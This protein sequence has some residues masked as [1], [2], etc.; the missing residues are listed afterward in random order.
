MEQILCAMKFFIVLSGDEE[1]VPPKVYWWSL[2]KNVSVTSL[3]TLTSVSV[4]I[5]FVA[6]IGPKRTALSKYIGLFEWSSFRERKASSLQSLIA[7]PW[8]D[9]TSYG[10]QPS[11]VDSRNQVG[12]TNAK[13]NNEHKTGD[14]EKRADIPSI[15]SVEPFDNHV[16]VKVPFFHYSTLLWNFGI[17]SIFVIVF[18]FG[19]IGWG[20]ECAAFWFHNFCKQSTATKSLFNFL[21]VFH[22]LLS[23]AYQALFHML[24]PSS[25]PPYYFDVIEIVL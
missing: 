5:S 16:L 3:S 19:R 20:L 6:I 12:L 21:K 17:R 25:L 24:F 13:N 22:S 7:R 1:S 18:F 23:K 8:Q 10:S 14:A 15:V 2:W 4:H 9:G 11:K